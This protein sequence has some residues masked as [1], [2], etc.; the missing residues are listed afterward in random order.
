MLIPSSS[1]SEGM[2]L[3]TLED[4]YGS[5]LGCIC[6]SE[7]GPIVKV[8]VLRHF[9]VTNS[10]YRNQKRPFA[11]EISLSSRSAF[12]LKQNLALCI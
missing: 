1:E 3:H 2:H 10:C 4:I 5:C 7:E 6:C 12:G 8:V 11:E 9:V